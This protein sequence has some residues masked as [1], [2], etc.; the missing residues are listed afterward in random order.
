MTEITY[1]KSDEN[2]AEVVFDL[3]ARAVSTLAPTYYSAQ[4]VGSWMAGRTPEDYRNTCAAKAMIIA[5]VGKTPAGFGHAVPGEIVRL[6]VDVK[7][8]GLGIGAECC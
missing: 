6:F 5:M 3:T 1:R 2:D 4:V 8:S 7:F